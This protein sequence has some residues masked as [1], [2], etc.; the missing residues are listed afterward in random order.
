MLH[1]QAE[2]QK[3]S[4]ADNALTEERAQTWLICVQDQR[5]RVVGNA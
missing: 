2:D 3:A 1:A 4:Q 5:L